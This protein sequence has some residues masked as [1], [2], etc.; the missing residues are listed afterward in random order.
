MNFIL[1][2]SVFLSYGCI[3]SHV[4]MLV[5]LYLIL[6]AEN[7][8]ILSDWCK[9]AQEASWQSHCVLRS[10]L[11]FTALVNPFFLSA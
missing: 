11:V 10:N 3:S 2:S 4:L 7:K 6:C 1:S 8:I 9:V 5:L